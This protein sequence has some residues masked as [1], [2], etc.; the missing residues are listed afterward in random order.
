[1]CIPLPFRISVFLNP[2]IRVYIKLSNQQTSHR[3]IICLLI[4]ELSA[5]CVPARKKS[6]NFRVDQSLHSLFRLKDAREKAGDD[7]DVLVEFSDE[8]GFGRYLDLH[9]AYNTYINLKNVEQIDYLTYLS[10]FDRLFEMAKERKNHDYKKYLSKLLDYVYG[11][12][13]RVKPLLNLE[14]ELEEATDD[15]IG[16]YETG[17]FPGWPKETGSALAHSSKFL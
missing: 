7:Q 11:F 4:L 3:T 17:S 5:I 16:K 8:E 9:E 12:L 6:V 14:T 13:Q 15:F 1:M 2:L 10:S